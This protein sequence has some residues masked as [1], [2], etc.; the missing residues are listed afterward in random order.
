MF[1]SP[2]H[3][4]KPTLRPASARDEPHR[5]IRPDAAIRDVQRPASDKILLRHHFAQVHRDDAPV[6]PVHEIQRALILLRKR[7]AVAKVD[8]RRR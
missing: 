8:A 2:S 5:A 4:I 3:P 7:R 1:P 6:A